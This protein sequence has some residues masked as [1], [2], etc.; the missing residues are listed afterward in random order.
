[1]EAANDVAMLKFAEHVAREGR[2]AASN[3]E[4]T[5]GYALMRIIMLLRFLRCLGSR[6]Q[7]PANF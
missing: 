7:M 4:Y 5:S 6:E 3:C 2:K 1:L